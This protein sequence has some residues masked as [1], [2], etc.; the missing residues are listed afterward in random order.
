MW[1]Y[2]DVLNM[3]VCS[4]KFWWMSFAHI[5]PFAVLSLVL[6]FFFCKKKAG[7]PLWTSPDGFKNPSRCQ[8][9]LI[10]VQFH[11]ICNRTKHLSSDSKRF[12]SITSLISMGS[13]ACLIF[14]LSDKLPPPCWSTDA[15]YFY[16][17]TSTHLHCSFQ[18]FWI[19]VFC[20]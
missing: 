13:Y 5:N 4:D 20:T 10:E 14:L 2:P 15:N 1:K 6:F 9:L 11:C 16:C 8:W 3:Y 19:A 18:P 7:P 12:P 17:A